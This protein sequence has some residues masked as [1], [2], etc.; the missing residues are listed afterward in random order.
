MDRARKA[1]LEEVGQLQ[2]EDLAQVWRMAHG[3][4]ITSRDGEVTPQWLGEILSLEAVRRLF[5]R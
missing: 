4:V 5:N 1:G 2:A 3:L